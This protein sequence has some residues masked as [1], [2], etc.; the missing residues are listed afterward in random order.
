[1]APTRS[2]LGVHEVS[3]I[4]SWNTK[5]CCLS[6]FSRSSHEDALWHMFVTVVFITYFRRMKKRGNHLIMIRSAIA[7]YVIPAQVDNQ[8]L[9]PNYRHGHDER[10]NA[11]LGSSLSRLI[12]ETR[13]LS[14]CGSAILR[15]AFRYSLGRSSLSNLLIACLN[16]SL[17]FLMISTDVRQI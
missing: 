16:R 12:S 1:M 4:I 17:S 13:R 3:G 7:H 8:L 2:K 15:R 14:K 10:R 11:L 9:E 5:I 6:S